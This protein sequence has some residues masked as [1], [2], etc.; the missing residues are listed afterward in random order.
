MKN[1]L[2]T[3]FFFACMAPSFS[4]ELWL[5]ETDDFTG[6]TKK[7]TRSEVIGDNAEEKAYARISI[8]FGAMRIEDTRA[9]F[10]KASSDLGCA[11]ASGNY[12]MLK[13]SDG[14]VIK[15]QDGADIDCEDMAQSTFLVNDELLARIEAKD[16]P[17]MIRFKQADYYTDAKTVDAETW[18]A[19]WAAVAK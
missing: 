7:G 5:D 11:G 4:Q 14:E 10:L 3:L 6:A 9:F 18:N 13:F 1:L 8:S 2:A 19:H 15:L 17:V 16:A 12:A